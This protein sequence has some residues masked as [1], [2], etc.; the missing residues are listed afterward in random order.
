M[1]KA[2]IIVSGGMLE[3]A[4][5]LRIFEDY[6]DKY[7]IGVD[8]GVAFLHRHQIVPD[9]IV[10]DFDSLEEE[11]IQYYRTQTK[12]PIREFNPIKDASDTEMALRLGM[13]I[14]SKEI[15]LLGATGNRIDHLWAN[16]QILTV[17]KEAGVEA[18]ILDS[19]NQIRLIGGETHLKKREAF[20]EYFSVFPLGD[21]IEDFNIIGAKYPLKHHT[22]LP[23]DSLCVSNQI[24][25]DEVVI[26]FQKGTVILMETKDY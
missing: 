14:G 10:G 18:K 19:C 12:V 20:G 21:T 6:K 4:F 5:A 9:Y 24:I 16:V 11:I 25:E 22:L 17:A 2:T 7:V 15:V 3:E 26:Q 23:N 8:K 13:N 1:S